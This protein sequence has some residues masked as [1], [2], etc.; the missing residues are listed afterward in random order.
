MASKEDL[1][2][3]LNKGKEKLDSESK[4]TDEQSDTIIIDGQTISREE[5]ERAK[6]MLDDFHS[7][8]CPNPFK[9]NF[10]KDGKEDEPNPEENNEKESA[11][12]KKKRKF[13]ELEIDLSNLYPD[14]DQYE[15]IS[16]NPKDKTKEGT[17]KE[18]LWKKRYNN[19]KR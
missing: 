8:Y 9:I 13:D 15:D 14:G 19:D 12:Q 5:Y 6:K 3:E 10:N 18:D 7:R 16:E 2:N 1:E 17:G 11:K 4:K